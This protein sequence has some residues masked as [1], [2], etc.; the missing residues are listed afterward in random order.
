MADLS[1]NAPTI[2]AIVGAF[3]GCAVLAV[4]LRVF[5]RLIMLK[6]FG[7]DD[8]VMVTATVRLHYLNLGFDS[9]KIYDRSTR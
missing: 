3:V 7:S 4:C 9:R 1:T 6:M 2:L 8:Y 5:V